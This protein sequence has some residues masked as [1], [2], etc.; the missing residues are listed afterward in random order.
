MHQRI[1]EVNARLLIKRFSTKHKKATLIDIP[2]D[3]WNTLAEKGFQY[4][5]LMGI[6]N[7]PAKSGQKYLLKEYNIESYN[8]SLKDW[9]MKD[10]GGSPFAI[11]S[12]VLDPRYGT[13]EE[14]LLVKKFLNSI[15]IKL[16]L[17]FIPNHF[18]CESS[19]LKENPEF[20]LTATEKDLEDDPFSFF[21]NPATNG[22]VIA[23]G[24]DPFFPAWS[25]TAQL[26]YFNPA[27]Q[28]FMIEQLLHIALL[29]DG[30]RCDMAM[31]M[32]NNV[33][34]NTWRGLIDRNVYPKPSVEF[35]DWAIKVVKARFP[36]F[37][38]IAEAYWDHEWTLQ[39]LGFDFTYDKKLHD[40]MKE[41]PSSSVRDHLLGDMVFQTKSVRF[42]EN[43]DEHRA[44]VAYGCEKSLAAATV[45]ATVPGLALFYDGQFEG[46]KIKLPVQLEREPEE[47]PSKRTMHYYET[48]LQVTNN[49]V[50]K[51]G[52]FTVLFPSRVAN[53]N[54]SENIL[55]HLWKYKG[56]YRLVIIN[57]SSNSA[58]ARIKFGFNNQVEFVRMY[59]LLHKKHYDRSTSEIVLHGLFVELNGWQSHIFA[60]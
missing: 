20:F 44:V 35:W 52:E 30:V 4:V 10:V 46:K 21:K 53:S 50:F 45:V 40:R 18:F 55:A 42:I 59:D 14:L 54:S 56:E 58:Q 48:L 28:H 15:N 19:L 24:R 23:H 1:F 8:R 17:D 11:D 3:Y 25:N 6:W 22:K 27:V 49:E 29:C 5:W 60:F 41:A 12:Y 16:I 57:F 32:L 51:Y 9:T 7:T 26:N 33:F 43:H 36:N 34:N 47:T 13:I 31:L 39:Q 37:T 2:P 38:M